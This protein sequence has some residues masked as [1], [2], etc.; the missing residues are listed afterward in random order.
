M[1]RERYALLQCNE[2]LRER[3]AAPIPA[4]STNTKMIG[5]LAVNRDD[6]TWIYPPVLYTLAGGACGGM[7]CADSGAS[8]MFPI[9]LCFSHLLINIQIF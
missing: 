7:V 1:E 8:G 4:G 3:F 2:L 5:S 6:S 9:A